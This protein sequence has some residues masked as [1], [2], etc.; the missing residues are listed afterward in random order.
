[1]RMDSVQDV[2]TF[3]SS[4]INVLK[5][6]MESLHLVPFVLHNCSLQ[7]LFSELIKWPEMCGVESVYDR[8]RTLVTSIWILDILKKLNTTYTR[9]PRQGDPFFKDTAFTAV[10]SRRCT[11]TYSRILGTNGCSRRCKIT[12]RL[13]AQRRH[14]HDHY[15]LVS[16]R[17]APTNHKCSQFH[18]RVRKL[19]GHSFPKNGQW[20]LLIAS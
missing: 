16:V 8:P 12:I 15:C 20:S 10:L 6:P 19:S 7:E 13:E 2:H 17:C 9:A 5:G 11:S 14:N 3:L 4:T 18:F 1:M